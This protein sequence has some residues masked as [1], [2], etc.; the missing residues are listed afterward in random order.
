MTKHV[1]SDIVEGQSHRPRDV[2][3]VLRNELKKLLDVLGAGRVER[4]VVDMDNNLLEVVILLL[5]LEEVLSLL[6]VAEVLKEDEHGEMFEVG[7]L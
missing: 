3:W 4:C 5:P 7:L 1:K 2:L 6:I